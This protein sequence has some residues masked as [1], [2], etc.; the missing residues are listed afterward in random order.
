[1]KKFISFAVY[2]SL[3][4]AALSFTS[5]QEE[6][7]KINTGSESQA[8]KANSSTAELIQKTTS[9]DGSYDNIVDGASCFDVKFPYT[10][11]VN[12]IK[13]TIDSREDLHEIEE[14][15][16]EIMDD[17]DTLEIIFPI[18]IT[19]GD[20]EE[21]T[22]NS[23]DDLRIM[24]QECKEGGDD[25]DIE[26]IDFV[27]PLTLFTFN[28]N[29]EQTGNI[30]VESDRDLRLFFDGLEGEDLVS[31][32]FPIKLQLYDGSTMA[33]ETNEELAMAINNAKDACDE[34]D[35]NDYD[36]DDTTAEGIGELLV[37]C[38]WII[39]EVQRDNMDYT[40]QYAENILTFKEDGNL[41]LTG[42]GQSTI[43]GKWSTRSTDFGIML[44]LGF[45]SDVAFDLEYFVYEWVDEKLKLYLSDGNKVIMESGCHVIDLQPEG[46]NVLL[47]ECSWVIEE[48]KNNGDH[49][50]RLLGY[51]LS[52][53]AEG[54]LVL[55]QGDTIKNGTWEVVTNQDGRLVVAMVMA[56]EP[57]VSYEWLLSDLK[58]RHMKFNVSGSESELEIVRNCEGD[59]SDEDITYIKSL[60]NETG[61]N[62]AYFAVNEVE[63]T[64]AYMT[65]VLMFNADG[66]IQVN[67]TN[68]EVISSGNWFVYRNSESKLSMILSFEDGSNLNPLANAYDFQHI[69]ENRLELKHWNDDNTYNQLVLER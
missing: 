1:M 18:T 56:D 57:A 16:D 5:C 45:D 41:V 68:N 48:V 40:S 69:T 15:F 7:E 39:R 53:N 13:L 4:G 58:D 54:A 23:M 31:F 20:Y 21:I 11:T 43:N 12:G 28:I 38:P 62:V 63:N 36:D 29:L 14:I 34:D 46:L 52:F 47:Q 59:Y 61:W 22:I 32:N 42:S 65:L 17:E 2:L 49:V 19:S 9:K 35:D 26:C 66:S 30:T 50:N 37:K 10:V 27:Y 33:V 64:T 3:L 67:N 24:A 44:D 8:I 51:E 55:S 60:F 25:D 6:F